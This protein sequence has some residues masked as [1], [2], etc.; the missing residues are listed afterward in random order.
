MRNFCAD[1]DFAVKPREQRTDTPLMS[2]PAPRSG[3]PSRPDDTLLIRRWLIAS[4]L[5]MAVVAT[6]FAV[7]PLGRMSAIPAVFIGLML[8]MTITIIFAPWDIVRRLFRDRAVIG[9]LAKKITAMLAED[10]TIEPRDLRLR[11]PDEIGALTES[12]EQLA[13]TAA[14]ERRQNQRLTRTMQEAIR[15]QTTRATHDLR[16]EA[17]TDPLTGLSNRRS[18]DKTL[19]GLFADPGIVDAGIT[20]MIIDVDHFKQIN[21]SLGHE[22]GDRCLA[23]LGDLL[24]S[25]LRQEDTAARL[26]GDEFVAIMPGVHISEAGPIAERIA[27]LYRQMPWSS[28]QVP[29]PT[30][31]IGLAM[32]NRDDDA[33]TG[34]DLIRAA[35]A[36]LYAAKRG[37]RARV[38]LSD[39]RNEAA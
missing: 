24:K 36:A 10:S 30:L 20:A 7:G 25:A 12:L 37:G 13:R 19:A 11:R 9:Q 18:L 32:S 39:Q 22:V 8:G 3:R 23:F 17:E 28:D 26:G 33:A 2:T 27:A 15:K 5:G 1:G 21:D 35:D 29:R 31:S 16:R 34:A 14:V 4:G 38:H 6:A